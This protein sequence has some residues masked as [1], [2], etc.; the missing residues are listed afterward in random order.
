[1]L[2]KRI[3]GGDRERSRYK[4]NRPKAV[5]GAGLDAVNGAMNSQ[6]VKA[7]RVVEL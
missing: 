2:G 5:A 7:R 4:K 3:S 6:F 1:M